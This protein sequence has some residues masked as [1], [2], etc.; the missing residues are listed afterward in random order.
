MQKLM[1]F[2]IKKHTLSLRVFT[3]VFVY[4]FILI[5]AINKLICWTIIASSFI[6]IYAKGILPIGNKLYHR[7]DC[8]I[9]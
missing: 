6:I 8:N 5:H 2:D 1:L 3:L 4:Q 7:I 9:K